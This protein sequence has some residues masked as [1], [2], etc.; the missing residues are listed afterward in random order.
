M[1]TLEM[2]IIRE[3][4]IPQIC[5]RLAPFPFFCNQFDERAPND[6]SYIPSI[7]VRQVIPR[8]RLEW[9]RPTVLETMSPSVQPCVDQSHLT[10]ST[11]GFKYLGT[12][13]FPGIASWFGW[14]AKAARNHLGY[15]DTC[16][17]WGIVQVWSEYEGLFWSCN[18][19]QGE[20]DLINLRFA[21]RIRN[22]VSIWTP[23]EL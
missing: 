21:T 16:V 9:L 7:D 3:V 8:Y 5:S 23:E 13:R 11:S 20:L 6:R 12:H 1:Y 10:Y 2:H 14:L 15:K 4:L 19:K 22:G 18:P 17:E